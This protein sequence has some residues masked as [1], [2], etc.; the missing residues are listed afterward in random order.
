MMPGIRNTDIQK[1]TKRIAYPILKLRL[2][3]RLKGRALIWKEP[4]TSGRAV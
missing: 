1:L 2:L 3:I 4:K